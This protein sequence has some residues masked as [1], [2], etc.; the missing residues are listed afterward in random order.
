MRYFLA[1]TEPQYYSASRF[2]E[3]KRTTWDGV[4]NPQALKAIRDMKKGDRVLIYHSGGESAVVGVASVAGEPRA[5]PEN[6]KLTVV[7]LEY[8][9]DIVPAVSLRQI[10]EAGEFSEFAL[11]RQSRL[12]TM[13][14]PPEFVTWLWRQAKLVP[15]S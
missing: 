12:S 5:D 4:R 3:D 10:K 9:G 13:A 8:T 7:D 1:K 14:V 6:P 2:R 11:V 15:A